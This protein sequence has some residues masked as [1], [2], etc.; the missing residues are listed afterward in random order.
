MP[1]T[2]RGERFDVLTDILRSVRL[3]G[4]VYFEAAFRAPWGMEIKGGR[5][6]N[7]HI[8]VDGRCWMRIPSLDVTLTVAPGDLVFLPHG[9]TH[10]LTDRPDR[11]AI[12]AD[13]LLATGPDPTSPQ[14]VY[15]GTGPATR[16]ICG[17][18][19]RDPGS[20]HPLFTGL[21]PLIHIAAGDDPAGNWIQA[22]AG[23]LVVE[24]RSQGAGAR[25]VVDRMAEALLLKVLR[26]YADTTP[27]GTGF[28][29]ALAD[30]GL[31]RAIES[32]HRE[33]GR[34]WTL[35]AL[36]LEAGMSRTALAVRFRQAVGTSP[37]RYLA[38]W[39]MLKA[40]DLLLTTDLTLAAIAD[41]SGYRSEFAFAR[42]FKRI[43][44]LPPG[45]VRRHPDIEED[46]KTEASLSN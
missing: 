5:V 15:G 37:I 11:N 31:Q 32:M 39:R 7:F 35:E 18:F 9:T 34:A 24:S 3:R 2:D 46:R 36:A 20:R 25:A 19:E 13:Q 29:T 17:H 30:A 27:G 26:T 16:L 44:G 42:A 38:E 40:R 10:F 23:L 6:A 12:P 22:A 28:L 45:A 41:R 33:P 43:H 4:T 8:V 21:P 14:P 1:W